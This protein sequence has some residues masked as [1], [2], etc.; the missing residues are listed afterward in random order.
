MRLSKSLQI[1]ILMVE[2][3]ETTFIYTMIGLTASH[4][5]ILFHLSLLPRKEKH[6]DQCYWQNA[7]CL[8]SKRCDASKDKTHKREL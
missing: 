7:T 8:Q 6:S 3:L 5:P 4:S 2:L 1:M